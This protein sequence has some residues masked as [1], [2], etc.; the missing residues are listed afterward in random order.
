MELRESIFL[1]KFQMET[2]TFGAKGRTWVEEGKRDEQKVV[3]LDGAAPGRAGRWVL[4]AQ[5][6]RRPG[7]KDA[8]ARRNRLR[9]TEG[10]RRNRLR[11]A[12]RVG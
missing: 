12:W 4:G 10:R 9:R 2:P 1:F 6:E 5:A 3:V 8:P 11:H 7:R